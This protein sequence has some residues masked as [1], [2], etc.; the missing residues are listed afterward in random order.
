MLGNIAILYPQAKGFRGMKCEH[1]P[2]ISYDDSSFITIIL[3]TG[4]G[5]KSLSQKQPSEEFCKERC[6]YKFREIH[7]K[8][9]AP[10]SI[11]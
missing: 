3:K 4:V 6:S 10:E 7:R 8:T 5:W 9:P 1:W 11:F 2:E